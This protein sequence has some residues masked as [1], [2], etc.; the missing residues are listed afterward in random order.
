MWQE[1]I[2]QTRVGGCAI[3]LG[4]VKVFTRCLAVVF[5]AAPLVMESAFDLKS[6]RQLECFGFFALN[7]LITCNISP[8]AVVTY[9]DCLNQGLRDRRLTP[10]KK[11]NEEQNGILR[12][13][14]FA[15]RPFCRVF[16]RNA[17]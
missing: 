5:A 1:A 8:A 9:F 6:V 14:K 3:V 17:S 10:V 4:Y 12:A 13:S 7:S 16:L 11:I 2:V 15:D